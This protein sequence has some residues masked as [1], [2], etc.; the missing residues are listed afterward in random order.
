MPSVVARV[1][2]PLLIAAG[3]TAPVADAA[4]VELTLLNVS[5]DP[6]RELY[7]EL[8]ASFAAAWRAKT[9][10]TV[11]VNASHGGSSKQARAVIDGLPADVVTLAM[12]ADVDAIAAQAKLLS[13]DWQ[14]QLPRNSAP[15]TSTMI[16][17]V[18][19]GNPK[20]I[21]DWDDLVKPGVVV[22]P[23]NPKTSG[24]ARWV[25]LAAYGFAKERYGTDE[26]A[27]E[28]VRTLY[29]NAPVLDS[30]ARGTT[31]TFAQR[32]LGDVLLNWEN[33][34]L[35]LAAEQ[36]DT[37]EVVLPSVS[38]LAEPVV[39]VVEQNANKHGTTAV[40]RAYLEHLYTPEGQE[41]AAKHYFR[42]TDEAIAKRHEARFPPLRRFTVAERFGGWT[43]AQRTHFADGGLFDQLYV[44]TQ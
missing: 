34:V 9:G 42:P 32:G 22:V 16:F 12:A 5:Y 6:T 10:Q 21:R 41:L 23:G 11:K 29:A 40:A 2:L 18:R 43:Q 17:A 7:A 37:I 26:A 44:A 27:R 3:C 15:Y 35:L 31:T 1:I 39:A 24:A 28:F 13:P 33:D 14:Q 25:Y 36:G 4:E 38:V 8:D 30:G 20:G 19:K